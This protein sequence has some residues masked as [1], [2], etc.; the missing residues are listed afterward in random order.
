MSKPYNTHPG[1][2]ESRCLSLIEKILQIG[3]RQVPNVKSRDWFK[4]LTCLWTNA[5]DPKL[6]QIIQGAPRGCGERDF[7]AVSYT[8]KHTLGLECSRSRE[9][10]VIEAGGRCRCKS[11]IRDEILTRVL[12]YA[13]QNGLQRFW[14]DKQCSPQDSRI[15]ATA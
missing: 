8:S 7:I 9:Y 13:R 6:L 12:R 15:P 2:G 1:A 4:N 11:I 10:T 3:Q 14:I 5:K